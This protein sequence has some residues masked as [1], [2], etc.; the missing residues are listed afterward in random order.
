[1]DFRSVSSRQLR[2]WLSRGGSPKAVDTYG[3]T[4]LHAAA[5]G[6]GA[7]DIVRTLL[8]AGADTEARTVGGARPLHLA[9]ASGNEEALALLLSRSTGLEAGDRAGK[10]PCISRPSAG[11]SGPSGSLSRPAPTSR[12]ATAAAT[13]RCTAPP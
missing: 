11:P 7:A 9:A 3:Y 10:R 4:P 8:D 5:G 12:P 13:R 1:M 6:R 2:A